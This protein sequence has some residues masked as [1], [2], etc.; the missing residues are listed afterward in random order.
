MLLCL[1]LV[2]SLSVHCQAC[3]NMPAQFTSRSISLCT[4]LFQA[5]DLLKH[6][7]PINCSCLARTGRSCSCLLCVARNACQQASF[8]PAGLELLKFCQ[9]IACLLLQTDDLSQTIAT[10]KLMHRCWV[11]AAA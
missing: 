5:V 8:G 6:E 11:L 2:C 10:C 1:S 4:H 7:V 9:V 3:E